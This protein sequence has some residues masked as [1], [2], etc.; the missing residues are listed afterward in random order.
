MRAPYAPASG[1]PERGGGVA[2]ERVAVAEAGDGRLE[3]AQPTERGGGLGAVD[4]E[5]AADDPPVRGAGGGVAG[6]QHLVPGQVDRDAAGGVAGDGDCH[7]AVAEGELVGVAELAVDP[8]RR[9]WWWWSL[10]AR[11]VTWLVTWS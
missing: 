9:R 10:W 2:G 6:E 5:H 1:C 11:C 7:G 8:G 4:V 3:A